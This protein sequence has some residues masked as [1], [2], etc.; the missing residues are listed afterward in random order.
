MARTDPPPQVLIS[1]TGNSLITLMLPYDRNTDSASQVLS[2][3]L[4]PTHVMVVVGKP[5]ESN[6]YGTLG[7]PLYYLLF[8]PTMNYNYV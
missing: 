2:L 3:T 6:P 5:L 1:P 8:Q 4:N 7:S